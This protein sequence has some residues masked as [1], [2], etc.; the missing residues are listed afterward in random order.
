MEAAE[1]L[2]R[3]ADSEDAV[4]GLARRSLASTFDE[5]FLQPIISSALVIFGR[6]P[7][8][9]ASWLPTAWRAVTRDAGKLEWSSD[10]E[11]SGCMR[12]EGAPRSAFESRIY[13]RAVAASFYPVFDVAGTEGRIVS[14]VHGDVI[15]FS[16]TW[17]A[18]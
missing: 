8:R 3:A 12:W 10:R 14:Q 17:E 4:I 16:F 11:R 15:L 1:A 13:P 5:P 7:E 6:S 18:P 2:F 9:L